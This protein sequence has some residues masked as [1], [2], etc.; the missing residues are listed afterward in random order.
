MFWMIIGCIII[1]P[2]SHHPL[3]LTLLRHHRHPRHSASPLPGGTTGIPVHHHRLAHLIAQLSLPH[4]PVRSSSAGPP[5]AYLS[6][7]YPLVR[8]SR[9]RR[10]LRRLS[11]VAH[12]PPAASAPWLSLAPPG[13]PFSCLPA[14]PSLSR[15]LSSTVSPTNS[16][17]SRRCDDS[18]RRNPRSFSPSV[19][20]SRGL[21]GRG[22]DDS[23]EEAFTGRGD[24][25]SRSASS[26]RRG[27]SV[28]A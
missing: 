12:S 27:F 16:R 25:F 13:V 9:E 7:L 3:S 17:F 5:I 24:G 4:P 26:R 28:T 20:R 8:S 11:S 19:A 14:K 10:L 1:A 23:G 2:T 6:L 15:G 21:R 22:C 18:F